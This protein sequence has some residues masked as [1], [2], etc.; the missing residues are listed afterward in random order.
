MA[1]ALAGVYNTSCPARLNFSQSPY[2]R[3][4]HFCAAGMPQQ[5]QIQGKHITGARK[6][7]RNPGPL[8]ALPHLL[9]TY[10]QRRYITE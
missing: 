4:K 6:V 8:S 9:Y 1:G 10:T 2:Q 5:T 3:E 7:S